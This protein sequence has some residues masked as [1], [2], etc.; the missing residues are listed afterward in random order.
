MV[1]E[2]ARVNFGCQVITRDGKWLDKW[3]QADTD[4]KSERTSLSSPIEEWR[5]ERRRD[6]NFHKSFCR[7]RGQGVRSIR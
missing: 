1:N 5:P 4:R 7:V 2:E 3:R 6:S